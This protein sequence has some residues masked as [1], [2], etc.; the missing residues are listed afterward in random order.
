MADELLQHAAEHGDLEQV[1]LLIERGRSR[2]DA[3][4]PPANTTPLHAACRTGNLDMVEL[5]L[6]LRADPNAREIQACGGVGPLH[7]AAQGDLIGITMALLRAGANPVLR[8]VRGQTPLHVAAQCG[9]AEVTQVLVAQG[10]DP[11]IR[12]DAG[13]NA[14]WW[15]KE[16]RHCEL[17]SWY[18]QRQVEPLGIAAGQRLAH[19]GGP[20]A[21]AVT[22]E[23]PQ[24]QPWQGQGVSTGVTVDAPTE[25]S[26]AVKPCQGPQSSRRC[27]PTRGFELDPCARALAARGTAGRQEERLALRARAS[28]R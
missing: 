25:C 10:A 19:A 27:S 3:A 17:V 2:A 26:S 6:R 24:C 28:A 14:A 8:D 13:F 12:D 5:L 18:S 22:E 15:A 1:A 23:G 9:R 4:L 16:F 11:H 7:I 20:L 21:A